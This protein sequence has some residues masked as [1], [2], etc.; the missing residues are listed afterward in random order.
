M[1]KSDVIELSKESVI[2]DSKAS[3]QD[4]SYI[5]TAFQK[6]EAE[7]QNLLEIKKNY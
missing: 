7:E 6:M 2:I 5:Q 3:V 4:A 1:T